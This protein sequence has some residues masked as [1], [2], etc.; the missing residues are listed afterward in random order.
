MTSRRL[1]KYQEFYARW[2]E[3]RQMSTMSLRMIAQYPVLFLEKN[4]RFFL[5]FVRVCL[6]ISF[7]LVR[8]LRT[9]L[10]GERKIIIHSILG[11]FLLCSNSFI[12]PV[13]SNWFSSLLW[14]QL[15]WLLDW[16]DVLDDNDDWSRIV[17]VGLSIQ[18]CLSVHYLVKEHCRML[19][20]K[21]IV[22]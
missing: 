9:F 4:S 5:L 20:D 17:I 19:T 10:W 1:A 3:E 6:S 7:F 21:T 18:S 2:A 22:S 8:Y 15:R 16:R 12:E 13:S 14:L 11:H